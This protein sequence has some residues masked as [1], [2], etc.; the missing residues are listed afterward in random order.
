LNMVLGVLTI[1]IHPTEPAFMRVDGVLQGR[2]TSFI[3]I[4]E[5]S[6]INDCGLT[7]KLS[8]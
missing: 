3:R 6:S 7:L 1:G 2:L 4:S 5:Y 8:G